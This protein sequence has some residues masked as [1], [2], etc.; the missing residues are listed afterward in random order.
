MAPSS[1]LARWD[2][3][4]QW[5]CLGGLGF[6]VYVVIGT[7]ILEVRYQEVVSAGVIAVL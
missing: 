5:V 4:A 6:R 7:H 1:S 2:S 3:R